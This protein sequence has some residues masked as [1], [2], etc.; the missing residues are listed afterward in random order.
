MS[1]RERKENK[2]KN[3][4]QKR[5]YLIEKSWRTV[6]GGR[7]GGEGAGINNGKMLKDG[8]GEN[9]RTK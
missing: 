9:R 1:E 3:G 6:K 4:K 2:K 8:K 7:K 5:E